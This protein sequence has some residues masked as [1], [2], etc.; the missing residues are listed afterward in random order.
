MLSPDK[1]G[2]AIRSI[3]ESKGYSQE[4]MAEMLDVSQSTY[5]CLESGKTAMRVDRLFQILD[6]LQVDFHSVLEVEKGA[7]TKGDH[8]ISL[9]LDPDIKSVYEKM[10]GEMK[11]EIDFL[12]NLVRKTKS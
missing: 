5:A 12:R 3:R 8:P 7:T 6:I 1:I 11:E 10:I 4:Y 9:P 2:P